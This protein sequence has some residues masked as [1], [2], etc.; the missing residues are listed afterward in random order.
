MNNMTTTEPAPDCIG[1]FAISRGLAH[2]LDG[3]AAG[4]AADELAPFWVCATELAHRWSRESQV[5]AQ[6]IRGRRDAVT[7]PADPPPDRP[8][9][10][11]AEDRISF[12]AALRLV[13]AHPPGEQW[14]A[15]PVDLAILI[16]ENGERMYLERTGAESGEPGL[17][18]WAQRYLQLLS[19]LADHPDAL[20]IAHAPWGADE[21]PVPAAS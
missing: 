1:P 4:V 2:Q 19:A 6:V 8:F 15:G 11:S 12:R 13:A 9:A 3:L 20:E 14:P 18:R 17:M 16:S 10:A 21:V 7:A 5:Q